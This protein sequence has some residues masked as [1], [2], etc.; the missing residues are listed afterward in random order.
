MMN[1]QLK[2][3][4]MKKAWTM[5]IWLL[6]AQ[7]MV[8]FVGRSLAPLIILIGD[9]LTLSSTQIGLLPAALFLGQSLTAVP[10]G[11]LVD[12]LGS[13]KQLLGTIILLG[14]S[15]ILISM[16]EQFSLLLLLVAVGGGAYA[17]MHPTTNRGIL[18]WFPQRSRGTA[19]GIKQMG[20]TVGS[21]FAA[22][23]L[24]PLA[25]EIGWR[26]ALFISCLLLLAIGTIVSYYYQ[27]ATESKIGIDSAVNK[28]DFIKDLRNIIKNRSVLLLSIS[29]MG[30]Q[31][32]QLCLTTYVVLFA[33]GELQMTL[34]LAGLLLVLVE[35]GGSIGRVAWG[36]ISDRFFPG[37][38]MII[39]FIVTILAG[40]CAVVF[41]ILTPDSPLVAVYLVVFIFG[42][43]ISGYNGVWM[44]IIIE[45]VQKEKSGLATGVTV[46]ISSWG[47]LIIP[48]LFGFIVDSTNSYV[49][50]WLFIALLMVIV[51]IILIQIIKKQS[52]EGGDAIVH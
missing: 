40:I 27:D 20:I 23:L 29:A 10:T 24:L 6:I 39:M 5:L 34:V 14:L 30:L 13:K 48:P 26:S 28:K 2:G 51:I 17:A 16:M 43:S 50:S 22:L 25:T 42:F 47:V 49:G 35:V 36:A 7:I 44:T 8:S 41:A 9:D 18:Y 31:G 4:T 12:R 32:A 38:R 52:T 19:M 1:A 37:N 11:F 15:F 46:T 3:D 45:L 33:F 21:A